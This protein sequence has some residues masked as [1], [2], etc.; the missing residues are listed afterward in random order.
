MKFIKAE[1][2]RGNLMT[3]IQYQWR[4]RKYN[5]NDRDKDGYYPL[6]EEWTCPSEIGKVINEKEFTLEEY[7]QMENA[8]VD[9]V[10]TFLEES[11]IHSL[12]ILKLSEQTITEEEKE[13]FLYDSGFEDLGFQEDKL[14]NKE[15]IGLICRMVLR[16][17]LYCELYLKDKFF[18]H[19]GWDYYMYIGS[20]VHCSEALKK[21]SKSGLFVEKMKS[22]YYVTE[23]EI[24]REMVWNKIGEDSVVGEET[25][26]GIDLDEFRKIFHLSSE[27]LVIGSFKIEKEHLDFFQKYVRHKIDLKKYEYSFWSYT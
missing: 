5:P 1:D 15:E 24:I 19:F 23:D 9:A 12:R 18:V 25:V 7:L 22:P 13:S 10:M 21:V 26:K 3:S 4:V 16:N 17:F 27:H 20:N 8:Y 6:K 11:G 2:W 14:M